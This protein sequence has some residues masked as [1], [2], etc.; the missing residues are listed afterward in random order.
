MP[1]CFIG[2]T[3]YGC[4]DG[5]SIIKWNFETGKKETRAATEYEH[6]RIMVGGPTAKY[7]A[8]SPGQGIILFDYSDMAEVANSITIPTFT[9][10]DSDAIA[11]ACMF[12]RKGN[13]I[14]TYI[15][16]VI[17]IESVPDLQLYGIIQSHES[18]KVTR[19]KYPVAMA[20]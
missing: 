20:L 19:T 6:I 18:A 8:A 5:F 15:D 7:I 11:D 3:V 9:P 10:N 2:D 14:F 1:F 17:V 13:F 4:L 16:G 12:D